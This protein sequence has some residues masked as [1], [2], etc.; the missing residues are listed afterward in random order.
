MSPISP[1]L[2]RMALYA[3]AL[4]TLPYVVVKL[5]WLGGSEL[6]M[7]GREGA[8][9]MSG[10]RFVVGNVLTVVLMAAALAFLVALTRPWARRVP[11]RLVFVLGAGA[12]GLLAPILLGLPLGIAVQLV[13]EGSVKPD[14]D[15]GLAPWV[16]GVVYSGFGLLA[17]AMA[18][19]VAAYVVD[20]WG[21]LLTQPPPRPSSPATLA[22]ALGLLSFG[23]AMIYWGVAGP[24]TTGPQGMDQPAQR[25]V[26]A[27]T[28][29]MSIA[30]LVVPLLGDRAR[31]W[32]RTAWLVTW[33]GACVCTLQAPTQILLAQGGDVRPGL[34]LIALVATPGS[35]FY[36]LAVLRRH[37]STAAQEP[38]G[39][40]G[41]LQISSNERYGGRQEPHASIPR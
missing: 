27:A 18:I 24:G 7:T 10:T 11:A 5:M 34:A 16:F 20:R 30:A 26:L 22:G 35:C 41:M 2:R 4:A 25:T 13:I 3:A 39:R 32:P 12:T 1:R 17:V 21:R 33:T 40:Q 14:D 36:G 38:S 31:R 37:L 29:A 6:G 8:E 9:E 28:G 19:L 15:T 23:A